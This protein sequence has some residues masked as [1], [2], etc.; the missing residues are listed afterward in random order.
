MSSIGEAEQAVE[1]WEYN[2]YSSINLTM[3]VL[4]QF[5]MMMI[6]KVLKFYHP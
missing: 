3:V 1:K 5:E 6:E 2:T 4:F